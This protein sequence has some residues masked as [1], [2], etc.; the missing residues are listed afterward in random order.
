[1]GARRRETAY[2][3]T[4]LRAVGDDEPVIDLRHGEAQFVGVKPS[5]A[6]G[7]DAVVP[8][9]W[10]PRLA[11]ERRRPRREEPAASRLP[12][13]RRFRL[14]KSFPPMQRVVHY[15]PIDGKDIEV[16]VTVARSMN[17]H[18]TGIEYPLRELESRLR[19]EDY[20]QVLIDAFGRDRRSSQIDHTPRTL[21]GAKRQWHKLIAAGQHGFAV[22]DRYLVLLAYQPPERD[23][24]QRSFGVAYK[25]IVVAYPYVV[26]DLDAH[27]RQANHR[28]VF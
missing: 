23:S 14:L 2:E 5:S 12:I 10:R 21:V 4:A 28:G 13:P 3:L 26:D 24:R 17:L 1:M 19:E 25:R 8:E 22:N 11:A 27:P 7:Y 15:G 9:A 20:L 6:Y 16:R 18:T